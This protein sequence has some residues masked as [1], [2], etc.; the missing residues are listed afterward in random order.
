MFD[1]VLAII[2]GGFRLARAIV[3]CIA[4]LFGIVILGELIHCNGGRDNQDNAVHWR[5]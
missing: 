5:P 3:I 1:I 2:I 4:I